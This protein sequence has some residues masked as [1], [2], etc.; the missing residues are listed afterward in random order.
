VFNDANLL[1]DDYKLI[2]NDVEVTSS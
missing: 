1:E 2:E